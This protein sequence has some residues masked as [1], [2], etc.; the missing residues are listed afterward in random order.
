MSDP[1]P[2]GPV[3]VRGATEIKMHENW[4]GSRGKLADDIALIRVDQK[5]PLDGLVVPICLPW[6]QTIDL[7][8]SS[9][10]L[11]GWG[12]TSET[13]KVQI[14]GN[15]A[16]AKNVLQKVQVQARTDG[17]C[18]QT[19]GDVFNSTRQI[20]A[21]SDQAKDSCQGDS[22]GPLAW[23]DYYGGWYQ[24]GIV[25]FGKGCA[26]EGVPA[27]YTRLTAYMDW[28]ENNIY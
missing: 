19:Y 10:T 3:I 15:V 25:S 23:R 28:I 22:G 27:V 21:G 4:R 16:A 13:Q 5:I 24:V 11:S 1:D 14:Q 2:L 17:Q 7:Q 12:R 6:K 20:C 18:E 9:L 8:D 26:R